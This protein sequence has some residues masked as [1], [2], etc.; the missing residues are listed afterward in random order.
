L[1][2]RQL[3]AFTLALC[4]LLLS[5]IGGRVLAANPLP[6][7]PASSPSPTTATPITA[8]PTAAVPSPTPTATPTP[9][10]PTP[11]IQVRGTV[12]LDAGNTTVYR[13]G[14]DCLTHPLRLVVLGRD[15]YLLDTGELKRVTLDAEPSCQV[16]Q[17]PDNEVDGVVVQEIGD[18]SLSR[19]DRSLL[20]LDRAG[21]VF[22]YTP[23]DD[24]WRI[25]RLAHDP[26]ASSNQYLVTVSAFDDAFYLLDTNLGHIW[27]HREGQAETVAV[28]L[29]LQESVDLAVGEG[30]FVLAEE[31]YRGPVRL[32]RL[33]G[34]PLTPDA[35]FVPPSDLTNPSL[36][37]LDQEAG[38]YLYV[39]DRD[40]R[41]LRVLDPTSGDLVREYLL[42]AGEAEIHAAYAEQQKVYLASG[43]AIYLYPSEPSAAS[44][45][46]PEPLPT[47]SLSSV[48]PHDSRVLGLLPS[49]ILPIEGTQ[50]TNLSFRLPGAPRS[51][52]YGVHEGT[53][54]YWAAGEPVTTTTPVLSV[55]AGEIVRIDGDYSPPGVEE[56]EAMLAHAAE[57]YHTPDDVLDV[58]RGR[59]VWIDHG[60]GLVSRYCHL[61]AVAEDLVVGD[62]VQQ[63]QRIGFVGN[64]GTPASYYGQGLE[65]HLHLEI[66][67]GEGYL[68]QYL[69]PFEVKR[70]LNQAFSGEA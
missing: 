22:R 33:S 69:R 36:L 23:D 9:L 32:H 31:G 47:V 68:G 2:P 58:L 35:H 61:S 48:S 39:V 37:F 63:G 45:S 38:G 53:D 7:H 21:N 14:H 46:Q 49:L 51:Y 16:V 70:W 13:L 50:L 20:I 43:D 64:S 42:G 18:I 17:P 67:I 28:D 44:P 55:A 57:V 40:Q 1:P 8:T 27:Q 12:V 29:D 56:I 5:L 6:I 4:L 19:G 15:A 62:H 25:E 65:M 66:R 11:T 41:R 59:Q 10:P 52:R 26:E 3:G 34:S 54:F 60:D 24:S 30:F